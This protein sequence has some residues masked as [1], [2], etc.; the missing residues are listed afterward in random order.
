MKFVVTH[1][2]NYLKKNEKYNPDAVAILQPTSP[3]RTVKTINNA[4]KI[5]VR[6]KP[7]CLTSIE[8]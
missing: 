1:V 2:L 3:M 8:K 6:K 5:F 7:D 4:C